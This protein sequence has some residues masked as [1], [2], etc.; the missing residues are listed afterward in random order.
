MRAL[1]LGAILVSLVPQQPAQG[2][3]RPGNGI[4]DP[5]LVRSVQPRYTL[6][7]IKAKI[8]GTVELEAV[9]LTDGTV[10]DV[11][12][13]KSLDKDLGLDQAAIAAA[14]QWT[15]RPGVDPN[16]NPVK[17]I[18]TLK[19]EFKL[20]D[21]ADQLPT[22]P[23]RAPIL[24]EVPQDFRLDARVFGALGM[25]SPVLAA[26]VEPKYTS[27]AMLAKIQGTVDV[28]VVIGPD[29][30]VARARIARSLDAVNGLDDMALAAAKQWTFSP[31]LEGLK[32]VP[33]L[34]R[35]TLNFRL[36]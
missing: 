35:I 20:T 36:H 13:I 19:L 25:Q 2:V 31:G 32:P 21:R 34:A 1:L 15:F 5:K 27:P 24:S 30:R 17:V 14:K 3:V 18:V 28:D 12:I 26:S 33:V 4:V 9:V 8:Q 23:L 10:G 29:G 6:E 7:A 22:V 11:T 16:G